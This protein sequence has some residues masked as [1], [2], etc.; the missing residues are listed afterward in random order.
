VEAPVTHPSRGEA[1]IATRIPPTWKADL[2]RVAQQNERSVA[3]EL[4]L[5]VRRHLDA[6]RTTKS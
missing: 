6:E 5:L 4:R 3:G 1:F 2:L